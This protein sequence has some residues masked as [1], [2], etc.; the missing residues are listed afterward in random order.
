[1]DGGTLEI[2][3]GGLRPEHIDNALDDSIYFVDVN[4]LDTYDFAFTNEVKT[5]NCRVYNSKKQ[6]ITSQIAPSAFKWEKFWTE[7][8]MPDTVWNNKMI[9]K[10]ST[11]TIGFTEAESIIKCTVN[12]IRNKP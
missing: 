10:G 12:G 6:D 2:V 4:C 5:L 11:I 1:M 3:N 8:K 7:S 9:G